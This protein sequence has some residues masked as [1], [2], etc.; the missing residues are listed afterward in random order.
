MSMSQEVEALLRLAAERASAEVM[1][2]SLPHTSGGISFLGT[3]VSLAAPT[4]TKTHAIRV[5]RVKIMLDLVVKK[6]CSTNMRRQCINA[7]Y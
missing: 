1:A 5:P 4:E 2:S 3:P 6:D 7:S